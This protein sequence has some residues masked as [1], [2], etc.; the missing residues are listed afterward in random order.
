MLL[1]ALLLLACLPLLH[2]ATLPRAP[3]DELLPSPASCYSLAHDARA[4]TLDPLHVARA[5]F[6]S[7][8]SFTS[9]LSAWDVS[10]VTYMRN[11]VRRVCC[12]RQ[13]IGLLILELRGL[14]RW[15]RCD[16]AGDQVDRGTP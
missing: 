1:C 10:S 9:D 4:L 13:V 11:M 8:I 2:A 12:S 6:W 16:P 14:L 15:K 7:A 3:A 5:Q